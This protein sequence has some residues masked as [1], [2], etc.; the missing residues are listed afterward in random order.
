MNLVLGLQIIT[1]MFTPTAFLAIFIWLYRYWPLAPRDTRELI[2]LIFAIVMFSFNFFF[3][4]IN[5]IAGYKRKNRDLIIYALLMPIYWIFIGLASWRAF[6]QLFLQPF[7]WE[8]T[9]HGLS[10]KDAQKEVKLKTGLRALAYKKVWYINL[11]LYFIATF[12]FVI[13]ILIPGSQIFYNTSLQKIL[14]R[15]KTR[16]HLEQVRVPEYDPARPT[17][18][19]K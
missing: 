11:G 6:F 15:F 13:I 8:K 16:I 7:F 14:P 18:L 4:A 2:V 1:T 17:P 3:I 10:H 12:I 19:D 9:Q 5:M